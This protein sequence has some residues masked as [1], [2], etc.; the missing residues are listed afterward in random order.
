[1]LEDFSSVPVEE[2]DTST[3][4]ACPPY[5]I[6]FDNPQC[7]WLQVKLVAAEMVFLHVPQYSIFL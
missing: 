3:D 6:D 5:T 2:H 7:H 1:M 4:T